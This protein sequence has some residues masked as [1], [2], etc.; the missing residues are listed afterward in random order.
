MQKLK[1]SL[2]TAAGGLIAFTAVAALA[3]PSPRAAA[4]GRGAPDQFTALV[5]KPEPAPTSE[6]YLLLGNATRGSGEPMVAVDP[7]NP[8]NIIAVGM[9]NLF[10]FNRDTPKSTITWIAVTHDGGVHWK[11]GEL[12]ALHDDLVRCPD[13]FA[14]VMKDGTFIA[15]CES[16]QIAD[17][18]FGT[19]SV[20]VSYDHGDSWGPPSDPITSLSMARYAPGLRP[21]FAGGLPFDRPFTYI[22]DSTGVVYMQGAGGSTDV[23]APPGQFRNQS[24]ITASTD[25][26]KSW[27]TI[28]SWDSKDYPQAGRGI[29]MTAG[30]GEAAVVY[31]AGKAPS[32]EKATCPCVVMGITKDMGKS[33]DYHV[34]KN[35]TPEPAQ[36]AAAAGA[37]R[38]AAA[39]GLVGM[40][41]DF[42]KAGR[43]ALLKYT[44]ENGHPGFSVTVSEDHGQTW[45]PFVTA[46]TSADATAFDRQLAFQFDRNGV[47]AIAWRQVYADGT[48]DLWSAIS[49][50]GGYH[51]SQP[52]QVSHARSPSRSYHRSQTQ[53][54]DV[55]DLSMDK[56][57]IHFVW[58]DQRAGFLGSWYAKVALSSYK[59]PAP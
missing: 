13:P 1:S 25:G 23:G 57:A 19:D 38:S 47:L 50:D 9:G 54:D 56:D 41:A 2:L 11:I 51:F 39:G 35:F 53:N 12:P 15:G 28:Y 36:G 6:E 3:Q 14:D 20:L 7:V 55:V 58:G 16:L 44:V 46:A 4:P 45:S 49:K 40:S 59:F 42:T 43:Y 34:L 37:G 8:N 26:A 5:Q 48:Y 24:Y 22:D 30:H 33:F 10:A 18:R 29:A 32:K 21:R 31:L 52:L 27:G 17:P